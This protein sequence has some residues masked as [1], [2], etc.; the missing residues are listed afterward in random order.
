M[1]RMSIVA[2]LAQILLFALMFFGCVDRFAGENSGPET[3]KVLTPEDIESIFA[4]VTVDE[5]DKY[6]SD[7]DEA[8]N[9]IVYW[10]KGGEVWHS[11][12]FCG[13]ISRAEP[14][15]VFQGSVSDAVIA[16]KKRACKT[17]SD[18]EE[19]DY[20][21]TSDETF[22]ENTDTISESAQESVIVI[23]ADTIVYWLK[24]GS[25][26]HL[27][28]SCRS[29]SGSNKSSVISGSLKEAYSQGK[30]RG[31]KNCSSDVTGDYIYTETTISIG[32][33]AETDVITEKYPAE[34]GEDGNQIV[35]WLES[36]K[37]WHM[38]KHCSN[39]SRTDPDK[40]ISGTVEDAIKAGKERVCKNCS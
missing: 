40:L 26:W 30:E 28:S 29:L 4:S 16:G 7:T 3:P 39:L 14:D 33:D 5:I 15:S 19:F 17:C 11:S 32:T 8:G 38:S 13:S 10:L 27:D 25:V 9:E 23:D 35:F 31:C 20:V 37:I 18:G 22:N 24:N 34:Y 6:P 12:K 21:V 36:S 1:K 2:M